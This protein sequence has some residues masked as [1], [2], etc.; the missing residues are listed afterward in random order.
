LAPLLAALRSTSNATSASIRLTKRDGIPYLVITIATTIERWNPNSAPSSSH[1]HDHPGPQNHGLGSRSDDDNVFDTT[2]SSN[3]VT[4]Q[5]PTT[6]ETI[7]TQDIPVRVLAPEAVAGLHEPRCR[8]PDVH[9]VLPPLNQLKAVSD[10]FTKLGIATASTSTSNT[11]G[12][13][14]DAG[15]NAAGSGLGNKAP[16]LELSATMHGDLRLALR[17]DGLSIAST[18]QGLTNPE[19]DPGAVE[20]GEDGVRMHPSTRMRGRGGDNANED[21]A[22]DGN[23]DEDDMLQR[24]WARVRIDSRDWSKVLSVGRLGGRVIA[25][26]FCSCCAFGSTSDLFSNVVVT[27]RPSLLLHLN[28]WNAGQYTMIAQ[29]T[30]TYQVSVTIMHLYSTYIFRARTATPTR[31]Y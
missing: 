16:R 26:E 22:A 21:D 9:I 4:L 1:H 11:G 17:N 20:G 5:A 8:E 19:L 30:Y 25:C 15:A 12:G 13:R 29:H 18:W 14:G 2:N 10:R 23:D 24:G 7:I 28:G 27:S 31:A 6:H 3:G